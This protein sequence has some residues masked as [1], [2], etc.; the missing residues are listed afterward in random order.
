ML[1]KKNKKLLV[2]K[3]WVQKNF[4]VQKIL[5]PKKILDPKQ[6]SGQTKI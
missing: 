4:V 1:G 5:G 2:Q 3:N 6:N